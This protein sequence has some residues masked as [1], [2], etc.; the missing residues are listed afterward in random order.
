MGASQLMGEGFIGGTQPLQPVLGVRIVAQY[1]PTLPLRQASPHAVVRLG[2][3]S[4]RQTLET[5]LALVAAHAD[6]TLRCTLHEQHVRLDG[7]AQS[8]RDPAL[9]IA[10]R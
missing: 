1:R 2:L 7:R 4:I 6:L 9:V 5:N 10:V 3:E 8:A